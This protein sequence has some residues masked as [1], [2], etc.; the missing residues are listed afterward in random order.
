MIVTHAMNA[1][2]THR[3]PGCDAALWQCRT[4]GWLATP[5]H[6]N[7]ENPS[8]PRGSLAPLSR[9]SSQLG[10]GSG[11]SGHFNVP[12]TMSDGRRFL[13]NPLPFT[14]VAIPG[15]IR[16]AAAGTSR[17]WLFCAG[18][19]GLHTVS[20]PE[21]YTTPL[22]SRPSAFTG[23]PHPDAPDP[24]AIIGDRLYLLCSDGAMIRSETVAERMLPGAFV[25][26]CL[27]EEGWV[28]VESSQTGTRIHRCDL[29]GNPLAPPANFS[30]RQQYPE[31][32][33]PVADE[34]AAYL[35]DDRGQAWRFPW[36]G[37]IPSPLGTA[38]GTFTTLML[39]G[40]ILYVL[41]VSSSDTKGQAIILATGQA[42]PLSEVQRSPLA[43]A[44]DD[45][46]LWLGRM[47]MA[48]NTDHLISIDRHALTAIPRPIPGVPEL[49]QHLC[50]V[51]GPG[52]DSAI[53]AFLKGAN[54]SVVR[55]WY[56]E[57]PFTVTAP[58]TAA[59]TVT[60]ASGT[61]QRLIICDAWLGAWIGAEA[62]SEIVLYH[63]L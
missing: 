20:L 18:P 13:A 15:E 4:C 50:T 22:S 8:C 36:N 61:G 19:G 44:L 33:L 21:T 40:G 28:L 46:R 31:W 55:G 23:Q 2:P 58:F 53:I 47:G 35:T 14:R 41:P 32:S 5:G 63:L 29:E 11:R 38:P 51:S 56:S 6:P 12:G 30:D 52:N 42:H 24:I 16:G 45:N 17:L 34:D 48:G 37:G 9:G 7:C 60:P 59:L 3:C 25:A 43:F 39:D 10:G 54:G 27:H 62:G 57:P 1:T 26:Q 49:A